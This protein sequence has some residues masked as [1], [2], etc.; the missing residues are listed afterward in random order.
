MEKIG[1]GDGVD[2]RVY[3]AGPLNILYPID[4]IQKLFSMAPC[5]RFF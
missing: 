4:I 5:R 1:R 3:G 2:F